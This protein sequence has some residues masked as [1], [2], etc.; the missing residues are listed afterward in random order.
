MV[1]QHAFALFGTKKRED[2][3]SK[4]PTLFKGEKADA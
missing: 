2:E 4:A 3:S 1:T